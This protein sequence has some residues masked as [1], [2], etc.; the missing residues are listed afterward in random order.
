M[1]P[2]FKTPAERVEQEIRS[3]CDG[4]FMGEIR[5]EGPHYVIYKWIETEKFKPGTKLETRYGK[6]GRFIHVDANAYPKLKNAK[7]FVEMRM[8][9]GEWEAMK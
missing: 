7:W 1:T 9:K 3:G 2:I 5:K 6:K 4:S 8:R